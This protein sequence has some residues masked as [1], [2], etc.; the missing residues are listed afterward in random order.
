MRRS[1]ARILA[2]RRL[3][4][5]A[6]PL[7][8]FDHGPVVLEMGVSSLLCG[9]HRNGGGNQS[10][11][12]AGRLG[13]RRLAAGVLSPRENHPQNDVIWYIEIAVLAP[14]VVAEANGFPGVQE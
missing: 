1:D 7:E 4:C 6:A 14:Y 8:S 11:T 10:L 3:Y 2:G 12:P 13:A 9:G 5:F